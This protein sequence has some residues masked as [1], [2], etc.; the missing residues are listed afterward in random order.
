MALIELKTDLKSLKYGRDK[1]YGGSS[2][3]PYIQ[4]SI[5]EGEGSGI[6]STGGP[7]V[8]LSG[9]LLSPKLHFKSVEDVSRLTQMFFDLKSP[10]GLLFTLKENILSRTAV[11][12]EASKGIGYGGG[13]INQ[14]IY[15]P[16]STIAQSGISSFG[17]HLN[18]L[19]II[20][21]TNNSSFPGLG[22]NSYSSIIKTQKEEDLEKLPLTFTKEIIKDEFLLDSPQIL[23]SEYNPNN[24]YITII[25]SSLGAGF[26]NRLLNIWY[27]SQ[28]EKN[29]NNI[30]EY[31]GGPGSILGIGS[32]I[33]PFTDQRTGVNNPKFDP[34]LDPIFSTE[35]L[36]GLLFTLKENILSR[37]AVK[38]EASKG[39]GYGGGNINQGI[40]SPLST[41]AQSGISSFGGHLNHLGIIP[42]TNNSSF[43]GLGINSYSSIIKTQKEEDLEKLPLT[44]TKEIIK[45]EFL[46]DSPQILGSEYNPNNSYITI[47]KSSLGAG[48]S[49][50]LLNIWYT[51]QIKK[52]N[53]NIREYPGGPG[54]ILGI[55]ST[56]IPFTDQRTGINNPEFDPKLDPIFSTEK[57]ISNKILGVTKTATSSSLISAE[58]KKSLDSYIEYL[59]THNPIPDNGGNLTGVNNTLILNGIPLGG[60]YWQGTKKIQDTSK[61][62]SESEIGQG[63]KEDFRKKINVEEGISKIISLSPS[64]LP[65]NGK[66]IENRVNLGDPGLWNNNQ[67]TSKNVY[68]YSSQTSKDALDKI[69]SLLPYPSSNPPS[70]ESIS[71]LVKFKISTINN[72]DVNGESINLHF[73][74]LIKGFS[75]SY[76][77]KWDAVN[78]VGRGDT[79]YNYSGFDRDISLSFTVMAQSRPELIPMYKKLNYLASI[80]APDYSASGF[81]RGTLVKLTV[82]G[83]I[84]EQPGFIKS[85]T[86]TI[87]DDTTWEIGI[88]EEGG[89]D[90][91]LTELPH[92]I[93]VSGFSFVPIH[94]FLPQKVKNLN[95]SLERYISLPNL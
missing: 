59:K 39:I 30:L 72:D 43:P 57:L 73:R 6:L 45:D 58:D 33:I 42:I 95:N 11:K 76:G 52:N 17:G 94:N 31:S 56:I 47:I 13:N 70:P 7:D 44:F 79:L 89:K 62:I 49:N 84:Y 37:T 69:T 25:K 21:I 67:G 51:S 16:L 87:P 71:D 85:L 10:Q 82:G 2:N 77:A 80:L 50:R 86:Y 23:G 5:P 66:N 27:T 14:G 78:Y 29:N 48:F 18:H 61:I 24:P 4:K 20:P 64:Y 63:V 9:G 92:R 34:K 74:A 60:E 53:N 54:S 8:L 93:E 83:Y 36:K 65:S 46:L 35:K 55:G 75:D 91:D 26:S 28:I 81:M 1:K 3:Q 15:S 41:I 19:G 90:K 68:K 12:T 32:T 88:N 38:T 22:I 40:Y